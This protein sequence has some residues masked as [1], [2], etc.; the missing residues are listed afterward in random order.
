LLLGLWPWP[1]RKGS[2]D[3]AYH[4]SRPRKVRLVTPR[5]NWWHSIRHLFF[6]AAV[7]SATQHLAVARVGTCS[8]SPRFESGTVV[9]YSHTPARTIT[10]PPPGLPS[11]PRIVEHCGIA[12]Y[13]V[14]Q[15]PHAAFP[16]RRKADS[17]WLIAAEAASGPPKGHLRH[18]RG[19]VGAV[20]ARV[21]LLLQATGAG[22]DCQH[23]RSRPGRQRSPS[24][25]LAPFV[26]SRIGTTQER[27]Y[28]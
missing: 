10:F 20:G 25:K 21:E 16:V 17:S 3:K 13:R 23:G 2:P 1:R 12:W 22:S 6:P 26:F 11:W 9:H 7:W 14:E 4:Y 8:S 24:R 18:I 19:D 28:V 27:Y 5:N 15:A